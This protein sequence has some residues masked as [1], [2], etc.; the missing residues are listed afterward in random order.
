[1]KEIL[2]I[3]SGLLQILAYIPYIRAI[4]RK[5][6]KPAKASWMIWAVLNSLT[7]TGMYAAGTV[8][9]QILAAVIG[10]WA[11][12]GFALKFGIPGWT[13]L[14]KFCLGGAIFGIAIWQIFKNPTLEIVMSLSMTMLGSIPTF[15]SMWEDPSREDKLAWTICLLS[16]ICA[17]I[18]IP[19]WKILA[20]VSQPLTYLALQSTVMYLLFVRPQFRNNTVVEEARNAT[21]GS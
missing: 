20:S 16:S 10:T 9:P 11:I 21:S 15:R 12:A 3:A 5:Q 18:A 19:H 1:M 2:S 13:K 4:L 6:T 14:D 17:V 8:N 7:F